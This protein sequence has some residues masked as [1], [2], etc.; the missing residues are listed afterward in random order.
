M[1]LETD[2]FR[3]K[4]NNI[5]PQVGKLLVSEPFTSDTLFKRSVVL[6]TDHNETGSVGFILNKPIKKK[7]YEISDEFGNFEASVSF[8][9][10]VGRDKIYYLHTLGD[11]IPNSIKVGETIFWGGDYNALYQLICKGK[12]SENKI[13]F[14]VGYSGW[15]AG[16][17]NR[18]ISKDYWLVTDL[19]AKTIMNNDRQLWNKVVKRLDEKYRV[20]A[21]FPENPIHN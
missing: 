14:F 4:Y 12:I 9:G 2:F 16:Q 17:L 8:G 11:L 18:E 13:R 19:D 1:N 6:L 3:I 21:N 10:P 5:E 15:D 20:W 7:I